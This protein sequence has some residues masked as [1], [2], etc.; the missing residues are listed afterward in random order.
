MRSLSTLAV[1]FVL[2]VSLAP[3]GTP[4]AGF[5]DV[6]VLDATEPTA[7]GYEPG[8]ANLFVLEKGDSNGHARVRRRAAAGGA[9]T[10]AL[11][12]SCVD[13]NG[14]RGLLGIAFD[15]DYLLGSGSRWVYLYYTHNSPSSGA[16]SI[17]GITGSVNVVSRFLESG[18]TLSGEQRLLNGPVL[19]ATNHNAGTLRFAPDKS[20]FVS[21]GDNDTDA[22]ANPASRDMNDLRGKIL[23]INRA[24]GQPLPDNPFF[25]QA[26]KRGEIWAW[27]LRNPFRFSIDPATGD[28]WIAD[29]GENSWEE[30]DHGVA[31]ADY[32]YPCREGNVTFRSCTPANPTAPALVYPHY[33]SDPNAPYFGSSITGGPVYRG[34]NFPASYAGRLFFADYAEHWIRTAVVSG[35]T[36]TDVQL[37]MANG[38]GVVDMVQAPNGCLGYVDILGGSVHE[39]CFGA[40]GN[41]APVAVATATP[42]GGAAPLTVQF[43]GS[44]SS[45][46]DGDTLAFSWDFGDGGSSSQ[47]NPSHIY[48]HGTYTATL[49]VDDQTGSANSVTVATP[50]PIIAGNDPPAPV[51]TQP[52]AGA[53]YDAGD[54][55]AFAGGA[56]DAQD[57]SVAASGLSWTIVFHHATHT[58]PFL[59]PLN[60][61]ASGTFTIP[62][63]GEDAT[64]VWYRIHLTATDSGA[65]VGPGGRESAETYV[66]VLP[67]VAT[68]TVDTRPSGLG[69]LVTHDGSNSGAPASF[70]SV[71][72]FP[73]SI[74]A[75][76]P[77]TVGG[78]TWTFSGWDDGAGN[79][80]TIATPSVDTTFRAV[81]SCTANCGGLTD[82]DG[83]GYDS[84]A[85]GGQD[86][87]DNDHS[88]YPG[89]PDLCDGKDNDCND[90]IDEKTCADFGGADGAV[91]GLDLALLGRY[92]GGACN[93]SALDPV[94]YTRD[95]C[96]DGDDLVVLSAVWGCSGATPICH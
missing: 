3:A 93:L 87:D 16:C 15:P 81:F 55:I 75:P 78:R 23:R 89:A 96:I 74:G 47:A 21:M 8:S 73:R 83:D 35:G 43:I 64:N 60:G 91:N 59:G 76:S 50:I 41:I 25:N 95:G 9:V 62:T 77:Q 69:L 40:G 2:A 88:V 72:N 45:D 28:P 5:S 85:D 51:I 56:S 71:V 24:N 94:D 7:L 66:D 46:A 80:R 4:P 37:F 33:F 27:G 86:C 44:S 18:G 92:F 30:I 1:V 61:I 22:L 70:N 10:T 19:G 32:G 31:G 82:L 67:N 79:P 65:P 54:V 13:S 42:T 84:I 57:G 49:T 48:E 14:E 29:V 26:G 38:G 34:G 68:I 17:P 12:L 11:D 63:T 90:E 36:L 6:G 53:H 52:L 58:H 39:I 20:L